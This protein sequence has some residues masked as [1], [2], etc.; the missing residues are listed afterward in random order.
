MEVPTRHRSPKI[1]YPLNS[2]FLNLAPPKF[3]VTLI[4]AGANLG[5]CQIGKRRTQ[6]VPDSWRA[7]IIRQLFTVKLEC[8][9]A[10]ARA[11]A[12]VP[13]R[14]LPRRRPTLADRFFYMAVSSSV[15]AFHTAATGRRSQ[16]SK[17]WLPEANARQTRVQ[18]RYWSP[19]RSLRAVDPTVGKSILIK[20]EPCA[21]NSHPFRSSI[22]CAICKATAARTLPR[23]GSFKCSC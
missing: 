5:G 20:S 2:R 15:V 1:W 9:H 8:M 23:A 17:T 18:A 10:C 22:I 21:E 6:G 4:R 14:T 11:A 3:D 7:I 13:L 16:L 19:H 12:S